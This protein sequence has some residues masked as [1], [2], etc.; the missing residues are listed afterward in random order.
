MAL[1][2]AYI[3]EWSPL[4]DLRIILRTIPAVIRGIGAH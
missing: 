1:D 2:N 3:D 4:L